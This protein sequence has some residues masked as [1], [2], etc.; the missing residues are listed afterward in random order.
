MSKAR[1][2]LFVAGVPATG[3]SWLG[4][5]LAEE[6]GY[7]HID[8]ERDGG[9]DLDRA[10]VH[11]EWDELISTCRATR[12]VEAIPGRDQ[13]QDHVPPVRA[14]CET[15]RLALVRG[16]D[17]LSAAIEA[18]QGLEQDLDRAAAWLDRLLALDAKR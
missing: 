18:L 16:A 17:T 10:G 9:A 8:A 3:K 1:H 14:E 12:F 4:R 15:M 5:W 2:D 13:G 7:V 11:R 6:R